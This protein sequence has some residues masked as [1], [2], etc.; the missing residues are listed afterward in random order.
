ML[1][2][3]HYVTDQGNEDISQVFLSLCETLSSTILS[4]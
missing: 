3:S 4:S 1:L 2:Q